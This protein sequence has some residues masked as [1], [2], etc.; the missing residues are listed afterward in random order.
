MPYPNEHAARIRNPK[1][2]IDKSLRSKKIEDW[3]RLIAGKLI[4][5]PDSMSVQSYRFDKTKFTVQEAKK[6]LVDNGKKF[7]LFE[8]A[9]KEIQSFKRNINLQCYALGISPEEIKRNIPMS[10][11]SEIKQSDPKPYFRAYSVM[12]EGIARPRVIGDTNALPT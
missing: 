2:F 11:M 8:P 6:W 3:I 10:V 4:N 1:L 12:H 7:T 5:K 9:R